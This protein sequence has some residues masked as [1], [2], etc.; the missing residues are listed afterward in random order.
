[1]ANGARNSLRRVNPEQNLQYKRVLSFCILLIV[2]LVMTTVTFLNPFFM[3]GQLR[4]NNNEAVI[5]R[6]VNNHFDELAKVIGANKDVNSNLL[7]TKQ[8]QPIADHIIDYAIGVPWFKFNNIKLAQQILH[9]IELNIDQEASSDAQLVQKRLKRQGKNAP[10]DV[11]D[12]FNLDLVTLG[13]NIAFVLLIVNIILFIMIIISLRSLINDMLMVMNSKTLVHTVTAA[14]MWAGFWLILISGILAMIPI[15]VNVDEIA[16]LGCVLE[17]G[18]S[19]F[20]DYVIAG[21]VL[22]ILSAIPWEISSPNN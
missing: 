3:K 17:I 10:Y 20:L 2:T 14:G 1:M 13:G 7:T 8:T 15:I 16:V 21:V 9:D 6:H 22:Y 11:I 4:T 19:I 18:S 12:A 5:V